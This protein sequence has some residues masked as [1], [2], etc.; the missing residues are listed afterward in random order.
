MRMETSRCRPSL[1]HEETEDE[2]QPLRD[3]QPRSQIGDADG[4]GE[5]RP[6]SSRVPAGRMKGCVLP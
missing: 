1:D 5:D 2:S 3:P 4:E 6:P